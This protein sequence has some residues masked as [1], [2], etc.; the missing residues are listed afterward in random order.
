MRIFFSEKICKRERKET[1]AKGGEC[2]SSCKNC[3]G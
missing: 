2:P 3:L 1:K